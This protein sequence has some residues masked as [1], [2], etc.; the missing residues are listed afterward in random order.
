MTRLFTLLI[1][2][3]SSWIGTMAQTAQSDEVRGTYWNAEKTSHIRIYRAKNGKYYG[4]IEYLKEPNDENGNPKTDPE[5]PDKELRSRS[6]LGMVIMNSFSWS[7]SESRWQDGTIYDPVSGNTYD[8]YM[9][10][11]GENRTV[12]YLRGYMLGMTWLGRTSEWT[13]VE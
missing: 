7:E 1:L 8:G 12:L 13:R 9:Y 2:I 4:K 6:R 11:K 10:F 5:N 3:S